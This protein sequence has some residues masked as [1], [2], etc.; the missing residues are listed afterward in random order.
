MLRA[1]AALTLAVLIKAFGTEKL[2]CS[3]SGAWLQE[4]S[5]DI[6][7]VP[8][9]PPAAGRGAL[10]LQEEGASSMQSANAGA[11]REKLE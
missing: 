2:E 10:E 3:A 7:P 5:D 1:T 4:D 6:A 8:R 11:A 9:A